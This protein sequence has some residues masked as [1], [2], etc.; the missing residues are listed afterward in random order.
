MTH[1]VSKV[2]QYVLK[3]VNF[4]FLGSKSKPYTWARGAIPPLDAMT[5]PPDG[6][7]NPQ[8]TKVIKIN[9]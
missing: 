6:L 2:D 7:K 9:K 5:A 1:N 4:Y 3:N 8:L